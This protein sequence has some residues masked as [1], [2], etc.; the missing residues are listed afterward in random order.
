M[1]AGCVGHRA[2][3]A[4]RDAR[5]RGRAAAVRSRGGR[6]RSDARRTSR[7]WPRACTRWKPS[8]AAS[9]RSDS[10]RSGPIE[11]ASADRQGVHE[12]HRLR[13][14]RPRRSASR[15]ARLPRADRRRAACCGTA[16]SRASSR[17]RTTCSSCASA[18]RGSRRAPR[19]PVSG[20]EHDDAAL[21]RARA[22][23]RRRLAAIRASLGIAAIER[24]LLLQRIA[25]AEIA[26][27]VG[28]AVSGDTP[29]GGYAIA[30]LAAEGHAA[31]DAVRRAEHD[32]DEASSVAAL[33]Y[34]A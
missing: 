6:V 14:V 29:L 1:S 30:Q 25:R 26:L 12:R 33:L 20:D 19:S 11:T 17:A 4:R 8:C 5:A 24:Q 31:I 9:S 27:T 34:G 13:G 3:G 22:P 21:A 2:R 18:R 28:R 15:R 23:L 10:A 32:E 7:G 16:A